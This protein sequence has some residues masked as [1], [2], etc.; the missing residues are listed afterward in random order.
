M[1]P[2]IKKKLSEEETRLSEWLDDCIGIYFGSKY[3]HKSTLGEHL[4]IFLGSLRPDWFIP[5]LEAIDK[6]DPLRGSNMK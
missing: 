1:A 6:A 5:H 2:P 3:I 4:L